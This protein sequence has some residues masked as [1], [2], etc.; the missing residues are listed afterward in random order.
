MHPN[1][2]LK[3]FWGTAFRPEV[4]VAMSFSEQYEERFVEVVEP[5]IESIK[6]GKHHLRANRLDA[7]KT[8]DSVL[9]DMIDGIAHAELVFADVS[10]LGHDAKTGRPFR[11]SDVMYEV[12][13][14]LA[15]RQPSEILLV[16]DDH[17]DFLFDVSTIPHQSVDFAKPE[18]ARTDITEALTARLRERKLLNDARIRTAVAQLTGEERDVLGIF[19][20]YTEEQVFWLNSTTLETASAVPRLLDKGFIV[21]VGIS[22]DDRPMFRWTRLGLETARHLDSL[23]PRIAIQ[24]NNSADKAKE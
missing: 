3:T 14:A 7:S 10:T 17:D 2:Y 11:N 13:L 18:K 9:T 5:A 24:A 19:S 16:R 6:V 8:G 4:F 1:L 23:V 22:A 20:L 21:A 15:C 12:G